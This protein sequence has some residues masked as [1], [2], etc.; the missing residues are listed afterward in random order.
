MKYII[1][2]FLFLNGIVFSQN[3]SIRGKVV[4]SETLKPLSSASISIEAAGIKTT[5]DEAGIFSVQGTVPSESNIIISYIGYNL[6]RVKASSIKPDSTL[7]IGLEPQIISSQT[8]LVTGSIGKE[9]VTPLAFSKINRSRIEEKYMEQD[10]PEFLSALPSTTFYS[11]SGNS[12]GYNYLSIR[13]FDQRRISVS[14]NGVPQNDP[15]DHN[16]YWLDFPDILSNS[17]LVQV[18][19]GSGSGIIGYPSIGGSINIITSSFSNKADFELSAFTGSFNT[20]KYSASFSSGL[21]DNTYSIHTM[22]SKT[23]SSGYRNSAWSNFNAYYVSAVRFDKNLTT[24]LN[25]YG[26]PVSDGLAYTGLPKFAI[27]DKNL[28][29]MNYSYWEAS[30]GKYDYTLERRPEEIENFSQP[31]FE[32]LNEYN[33]NDHVSFNSALFMVLGTGFFDYDASWADTSYF[34]LTQ[35]NGFNPSVNPGNA[36]IR[37]QVE[38]K[39]FG[40][41]PRLRIGHENGEFVL[42]AELRVHR[43]LHWGGINYADYLPSGIDK[44]YRYYEYKGGKDIFNVFA[45]E[46]YNISPEINILAEVQLAYFKYR[47]YDEK[48]LGNSFKAGNIF[49][50]PRLGFNYKISPEQNVYISAARVSREPRLVNYYDAAE[51]SGGA[52]PQFARTADGSF[53]FDNPL[54]SPETMNDIEAGTSYLGKSYSAGLNLFYML[55]NNEIVKKGQVDRFGQPVT[56]NMDKTVHSGIELNASYR[57]N[58]NLEFSFNGTYSRNYI[59]NGE[60]FIKYKDALSGKKTV[61]S[62]SLD[63]N[64]ISGFPDILLNGSVKLAVGGLTSIINARYVGKYYSDN[65]DKNLKSYLASYPGFNDYDDNVVVPYFTADIFASYEVKLPE[66]SKSLKISARVNNI[67]NSLYA[68]YAIGGEFFPAAERNFIAGLQLSL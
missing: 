66:F 61:S 58:Q 51:A 55:F 50:N 4:D 49:L 35:A 46:N 5:T 39:Q 60:T 9:G 65:Y 40:W 29:R 27:K 62:L 8:I 45:H 2:L 63:G 47:L 15:E 21:I 43:S 64:R 12:I 57:L 33:I 67:F 13:G 18:Q 36:L 54:V 16:V 48:Y 30:N 56:G 41:V 7:L 14:I 38:N 6:K 32:L 28:R 53:D 11:E 52:E 68:S 3:L 19:R 1:I 25:F 31:H 24:Q 26:G 17:E 22:L 23:M 37:A 34:R 42:G 10:V 20:R 44:N 59:M